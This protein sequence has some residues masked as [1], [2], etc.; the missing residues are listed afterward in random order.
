VD[1]PDMPLQIGGDGEGSFTVLAL[2]RLLTRVGSQVTS[3]VC[4]TGKYFAAVFAA[5]TTP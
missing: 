5:V 3:Q 1:V 4:R 2:V